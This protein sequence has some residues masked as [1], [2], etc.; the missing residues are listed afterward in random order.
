MAATTGSSSTTA[1]ATS[2]I[3]A[4]HNATVRLEA[5]IPPPATTMSCNSGTC[6]SWFNSPVSVALAAT[7]NQGGSGVS[8]TYYTTDGSTPT[9]SS[10]M[11]TGLST[12]SSPLS[13]K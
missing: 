4:A 9:T 8:A 12:V 3:P 1:R 5:R 7:D 11:Y 6:S 10:T 13:V 2:P